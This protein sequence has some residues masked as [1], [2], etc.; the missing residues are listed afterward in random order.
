[1][2]TLEQV[3]AQDPKHP[4]ANHYYIH[5]VEA[6]KQPERAMPSADRLAELMPGAGHIVHMPAHIY[7]RVGRYADA[8]DAN[9]GGAEA[10]EQYLEDGAAAGLLPDLPRRT[11]TAFSPTRPRWRG[12]A[13]RRLRPRTKSADDDP[14]RRRVRR[15]RA[16]TSS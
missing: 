4:G 15:C 14:A 11:T 3:L 10:D 12:A 1:M 9:R 7:Q 2:A 6:S 5:A 8:S 13:P 16:W